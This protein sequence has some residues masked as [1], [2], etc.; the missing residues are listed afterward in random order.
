MK[1]SHALET[2]LDA[3]LQDLSSDGSSALAIHLR[4]CARCA[5][6]AAAMRAEVHALASVMP[7]VPTAT[8]APSLPWRGIALASAAVMLFVVMRERPVP[9]VRT[10][11]TSAVVIPPVEPVGDKIPASRAPSY[12]SI[13]TAASAR[14]AMPDPV[15][16]ESP[17]DVDEPASSVR[18]PTLTPRP[19]LDGV[20]VTSNGS[21]T[22]LK[23]SNPKI[24]VIWF[25]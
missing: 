21:V 14:Y 13:G 18:P 7:A 4:S 20:S 22:I 2:M 11:A 5:R 8:R 6:V 23:T 12:G 15:P 9:A 17:A 19:V 24:T 16:L 25:K 3:E 10:D 1:C